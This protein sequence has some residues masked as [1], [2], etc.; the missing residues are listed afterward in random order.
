[1]KKTILIISLILIHFSFLN[2]QEAKLIGKIVDENKDDLMGV[3]VVV[4]VSKGWACQSDFDGNYSLSL[5]AGRYLVLISYIGKEDQI[6]EVNL[7]AGDSKSMNIFM[8]GNDVELNL[9][10]VSGGKYEK[11]FGEET[12]SM[13]ILPTSIIENNVAQAQEALNKVPGYQNLGKSPSIRGG[14]SFAAGASSR[15]LFLIDGVPQLSPENGAI[16]Y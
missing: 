13:E 1:M 3:N 7:K 9:V 6:K 2:A 10:T 14:S 11:K 15:T 8:A 12:V 5:P 4:D 16:Y